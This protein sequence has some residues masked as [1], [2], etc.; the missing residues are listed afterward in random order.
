MPM[1]SS[2][3]S[4]AKRPASSAAVIKANAKLLLPAPDGP[5]MSTPASAITTALAWSWDFSAFAAGRSRFVDKA[6][7]CLWQKYQ[8]A[9]AE[10]R[11]QA[12]GAGGADPVERRY[13]PAV[14][15][16]DLARDG[17]PKA[18]VLPET[19]ARAVGI[20]P[21][22]YAFESIGRNAGAVIVENNLETVARVALGRVVLGWTQQHANA[23]VSGRKRSRIVDEIIENLAKA[24]IVPKNQESPLAAILQGPRGGDDEFDTDRAG[25]LDQVGHGGNGNEQARQIDENHVVARH[26]GIEPGCVGYV[27]DQPIEAANVVR[28]NRHQTLARFR[29]AG[30]RQSLGR[31][32]QG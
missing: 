8:E 4:L 9:G 31:A 27:A 26:L 11:G 16:D 15:L 32:A 10:H 6:L 2:P 5:R 17:K 1:R 28:D 21:F 14:A 25:I 30:N 3:T 23:S 22:E 29:R 7:L 24:R 19:L 12:V 18:R 20:K 13:A